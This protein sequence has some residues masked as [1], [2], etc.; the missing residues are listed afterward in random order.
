MEIFLIFVFPIFILLMSG[1]GSIASAKDKKGRDFMLGFWVFILIFLIP[2]AI[3]L[4]NS[5]VYL[6]FLGI[7]GWLMSFYILKRR[8][9]NHEFSKKYYKMS[10][11]EFKKHLKFK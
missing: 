11:H 8:L 5:N 1:I 4:I 3:G 10:L 2:F 6:I 7:L 9:L